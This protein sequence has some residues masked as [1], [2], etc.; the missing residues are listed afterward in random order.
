MVSKGVDVFADLLAEGAHNLALLLVLDL[1]VHLCVSV[2]F[3]DF[4]AEVA[5]AAAVFQLDGVALAEL[6][7]SNVGLEAEAI[8][9]FRLPK[10]LK[11]VS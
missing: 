2:A 6:C 8:S 7:K 3:E 9:N 1:Y 5:L 11:L 10:F 4:V